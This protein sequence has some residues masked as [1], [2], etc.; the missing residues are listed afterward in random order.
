M[1]A[2]EGVGDEFVGWTYSACLL[3]VVPAVIVV[4]ALIERHAWAVYTTT[5]GSQ[6]AGAW[7][8]YVAVRIASSGD[9]ELGKDLAILSAILIGFGSAGCVVAY[10]AI[11]NEWFALSERALATSC[12]VQ[13]NYAGWAL[14]ALMFPYSVFSGHDLI[15]LQL[16]QGVGVSIA[17]GVYL[18]VY[19]QKEKEEGDTTALAASQPATP[20]HAK[21]PGFLEGMYILATSPQY[22]L[23]CLCYSCMAGVSF[24]VPA[25]QTSKSIALA[26]WRINLVH[27]CLYLLQLRRGLQRHFTLLACQRK[28][29]RGQTLHSSGRAWSSACSLGSTAQDQNRTRQSS[30]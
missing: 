16:L 29:L 6:C 25:F 24:A 30:R 10:S 4:M 21:H 19:R 11:A 13:S 23:Q 27:L 17:F 7:M 12:V 8:R 14:G 26:G 9:T 20:G 22:V 1:D 2:C 28:S 18:V 3:A 15:D 5:L